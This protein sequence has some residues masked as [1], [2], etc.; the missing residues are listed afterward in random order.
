MKCDCMCEE[1]HINNNQ[2]SVE[3]GDRMRNMMAVFPPSQFHLYFSTTSMSD[4][5]DIFDRSA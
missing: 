3:M 1:Q 2:A 4:K 5:F